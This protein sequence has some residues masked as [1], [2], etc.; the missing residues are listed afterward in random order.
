MTFTSHGRLHALDNL[1]GLMMWLGIVLHVAAIHMTTV[2]ILPWRDNKTAA[3]ADLL[4]IFI[5]TFRMPTFFI[6]AGF[7]VAL[8]VQK[9]G[10]RAMLKNRLQ[11]L[12]LP[13]A[14]FWLPVFLLTMVFVLLFVHRMA[15]GTWGLDPTLM[16][17]H[18]TVPSGTSTMHLWFLWMLL[19]FS[20]LTAGVHSVIAR[21]PPALPRVVASLF[22]RLG[23]AWWG[24]AALALPLAL[25]GSFYWNG[26]VTPSG[27]FIP[28]LT[29]WLHNGLFY[30]FGYCLYARQ[31]ELLGAFMRR[32]LAYAVLGLLFFVATGALVEQLGP[33][34]KSGSVLPLAIAFVY[35]CA[36]W[37]WCF[38][39]IGAFLRYLPQQQAL[40]TY[41]AQSSYW[42]Y[43]VHM[44]LT[45]GFGALLYGL[46]WPVAA[47]MAL[48][49][50]ATTLVCL[51]SYQLSVR[52]TAVGVLLNGR[53]FLSPAAGTISQAASR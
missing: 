53:R 21:L 19:W 17:E 1:R 26:V 34:P 37:L 40:L 3:W 2:A 47:K 33:L 38:A 39:L 22:H 30:V 42:V 15:R 44:P 16:P 6:L 28:P 14:I 29:E 20:V 12:G 24:F 31:Q 48:N 35:N 50:T 45:V 49:I 25:V 18:S 4:T 51:A 23:T 13:F 8:L 5:H 41:L 11:R 9:R 7:F 10:M 43:L 52:G 46:D 36:T 32:F 27:R